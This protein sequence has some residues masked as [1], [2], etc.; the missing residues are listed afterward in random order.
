MMNRT[1]P[2]HREREENR[3]ENHDEKRKNDSVKLFQR[4]CACYS[5]FDS[6]SSIQY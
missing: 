2:V 4:S 5:V 1:S 6:V 3:L